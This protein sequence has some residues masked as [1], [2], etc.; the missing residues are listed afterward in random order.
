MRPVLTLEALSALHQELPSWRLASD[1]KAISRKLV[2]SN[3]KQAFAF[4]TEVA[5]EAD[6]M[7]HHPEWTNVYNQVSI[8]LTTH[9]SDGV[10]ANDV[11]LARFIEAAA[12][13]YA[14][15]T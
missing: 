8:R 7:D 12:L 5:V 4:M 3:F 11:A 2:F 6:R 14:G 13:T 9:D 1:Y 10:T 15:K